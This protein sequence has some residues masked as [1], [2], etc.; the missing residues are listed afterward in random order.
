M[1]TAP[2]VMEVK[3]NSIFKMS[4]L[5]DIKS[6]VVD[7][8]RETSSFKGATSQVLPYRPLEPGTAGAQTAAK[9]KG[10]AAFVSIDRIRKG[11]DDG[12][13][14]KELTIVIDI[15]VNPRSEKKFVS[16]RDSEFVTLRDGTPV[17]NEMMNVEEIAGDVIQAIDNTVVERF[18][19]GETRF[20]L[21][22]EEAI[23]VADVPEPFFV[24]RILAKTHS[25]LTSN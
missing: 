2:S 10:L 7:L 20:T 16:Q 21:T 19:T 6:T 24:Y 11:A 3:P 5:T 17:I 18:P 15:W 23:R 4:S 25:I 1:V 14:G 9:L 12:A 22:F 13:P 8:V